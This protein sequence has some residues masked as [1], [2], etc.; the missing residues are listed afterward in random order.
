MIHHKSGPSLGSGLRSK[1]FDDFARYRTEWT[2]LYALCVLGGM[3]TLAKAL[4]IDF[5]NHSLRLC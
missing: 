2:I 4:C 5:E 3:H 1:R